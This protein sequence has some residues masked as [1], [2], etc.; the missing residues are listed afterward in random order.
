MPIN[1]KA[2]EIRVEQVMRVKPDPSEMVPFKTKCRSLQRFLTSHSCGIRRFVQN[3]NVPNRMGVTDRSKA[4]NM[5]KEVSMHLTDVPTELPLLITP[6][7]TTQ[8]TYP[9]AVKKL[10]KS[11]DVVRDFSIC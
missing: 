8:C 5:L 6:V 11:G 7:K 10:E 1:D 2:P 3:V 9:F 4:R